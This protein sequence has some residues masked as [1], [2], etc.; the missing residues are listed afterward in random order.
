MHFLPLSLAVIVV[1]PL[2]I[3]VQAL[4]HPAP[5]FDQSINLVRKHQQPRTFEGRGKLLQSRRLA[6]EAK[7]GIGSFKNQKRS[8]GMNL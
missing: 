6:L 2:S 3:D 8:S 4:P 5:Y 1:L 7:Y